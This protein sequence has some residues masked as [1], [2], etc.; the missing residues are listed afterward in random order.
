MPHTIKFYPNQLVNVM[1]TYQSSGDTNPWP[2]SEITEQIINTT[3]PM[4][5]IGI[6]IMIEKVI[7]RS[8][9]GWSAYKVILPS[10]M[11]EK[12]VAENI[13]SLDP[14]KILDSITTWKID[15]DTNIEH[16]AVTYI[17]NY[18]VFTSLHKIFKVSELVERFRILTDEC[19]LNDLEFMQEEIVTIKINMNLM[20]QKGELSRFAFYEN[21]I[22]NKLHTMFQFSSKDEYDTYIAKIT[23][24]IKSDKIQKLCSDEIES[25]HQIIHEN[26]SI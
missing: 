23:T 12:K 22:N 24:L 5:Y 26:S 7:N 20:K 3:G 17:I 14:S 6:D 2:C 19:L 9:M 15:P 4:K 8:K 13:R 11:I 10:D 25:L 18:N 21:L 1:I 16:V